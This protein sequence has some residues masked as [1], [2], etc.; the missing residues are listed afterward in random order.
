MRLFLGEL[1]DRAPRWLWR[2]GNPRFLG[3]HTVH[4]C[5]GGGQRTLE[6]EGRTVLTGRRIYQ[7]QQDLNGASR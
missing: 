2:Q 7:A 1:I 3:A 5:Y 4:F 6:V